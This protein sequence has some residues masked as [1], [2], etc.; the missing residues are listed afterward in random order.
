M[1]RVLTIVLMLFFSVSPALAAST[2]ELLAAARISMDQA[3]Q[4]A[5]T[6]MPGK[7]YKAEIDRKEG[8]V[9]YQ[10]EVLEQTSGKYR[11]VYV[12]AETGRAMKIK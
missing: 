5:L 9:V 2:S 3:I 7:A 6:E 11:T 4:S 12:D 1:H 10:V 8:R